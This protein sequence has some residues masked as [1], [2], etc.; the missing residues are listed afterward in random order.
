MSESLNKSN[1]LN[2]LWNTMLT[3]NDS[4]AQEV[5]GAVRFLEDGRAF[6]YVKMTGAAATEGMVMVPAAVVS[7]S[8]AAT[9]GATATS[10]IVTV[11]AA[12]Y[13]PNAYVG[14]YFKVNTGGTGSEEARKI[15]AN[16]VNTLT[17]ERA[18]GTAASSD[19][20]EIIAP[21]GIVVKSTASDLDTPMSGVSI[22]TITQNYYGWIQIEGYA[23]VLST[24]A[25]TE[26]A[27][28]S[29]GGATTAGQ[30]ADYAA[31]NDCYL[32]VAVAAGGTNDFQLVDLHVGL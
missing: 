12:A 17:L 15:V 24:S 8:A 30:A 20:A 2:Q 4:T 9:G 10:N 19:S 13:T 23:N 6:R 32:G 16:T 1:Q 3:A 29:P 5:I 25:L 14:Y 7:I 18:L 28:I 21:K 22:G 31:A 27:M 11:A 26:G